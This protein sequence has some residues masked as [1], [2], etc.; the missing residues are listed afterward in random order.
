MLFSSIITK[1]KKFILRPLLL[2]NIQFFIINQILKTEPK[3]IDQWA[4]RLWCERTPVRIPA[5]A[6][7]L[8]DISD[9]FIKKEKK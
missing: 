8:S 2:K 6:K 7:V 5:R 4:R 9:L 1:K 3:N